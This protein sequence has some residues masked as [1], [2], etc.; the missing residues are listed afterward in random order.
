MSTEVSVISGDKNKKTK[1]PVTEPDHKCTDREVG[2]LIPEWAQ[3]PCL[4]NVGHADYMNN[5]KKINAEKRIA[6]ALNENL[7]PEEAE[8][9][10]EVLRENV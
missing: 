5:D 8:V 10:G 4:Y 3:K 2:P 9:T 6:A 1:K 7:K